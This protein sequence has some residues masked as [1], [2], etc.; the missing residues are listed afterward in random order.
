MITA[1]TRHAALGDI[2]ALIRRFDGVEHPAPGTWTVARSHA[3]IE[4]TAPRRLRRADRWQGRASGATIVIGEG[5]DDVSIALRVDGPVLQGTSGSA[6]RRPGRDAERVPSHHQWTLSGSMLLDGRAI[7]VEATLT[8]R[9]VWRR[10]DGSYGWFELYGTIV[11]GD[12]ATRRRVRFAFELLAQAP[13]AEA[14][15]QGAA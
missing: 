10:G 15:E 13:A 1:T 7:P 5:P 11:D 8:Y 6:V 4:F 2:A 9:G 3:T 14:A 12:L